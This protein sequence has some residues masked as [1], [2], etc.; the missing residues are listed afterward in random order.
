VCMCVCADGIAYYSS[1]SVLHVCE[2]ET[3]KEKEKERVI[4][5]V[6]VR[7]P[8]HVTECVCVCVCVCVRLWVGWWVY[9]SHP[10]QRRIG[11]LATLRI[12]LVC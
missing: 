3:E 11:R 7:A 9:G 5:C 10:P 8:G 2:R 12:L 6:R 1:N 4:K